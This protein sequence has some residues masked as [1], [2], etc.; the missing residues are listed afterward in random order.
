LE[1]EIDLRG[2]AP[3]EL[4]YISELQIQGG[5]KDHVEQ[6]VRLAL[7]VSGFEVQE[8]S[9]KPKLKP[10]FT[11]TLPDA[12]LDDVL[13]LRGPS[14]CDGCFFT[15]PQYSTEADSGTRRH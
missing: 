15:L 12:R 14:T 4:Q 6:A 9:D 3:Q 7:K 1:S 11:M 10:A 13:V 5:T 8:D 2:Q